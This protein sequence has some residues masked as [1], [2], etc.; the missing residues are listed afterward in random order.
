MPS[1]CGTF[2]E[3]RSHQ[4][5]R[6]GGLDKHRELTLIG[7]ALH[8]GNMIAYL[9]RTWITSREAMLRSFGMVGRGWC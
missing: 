5:I 6:C 9:N 3:T 4:D 7:V 2:I 1:H 8:S